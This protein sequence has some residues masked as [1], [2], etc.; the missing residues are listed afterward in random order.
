MLIFNTF[1]TSIVQEW[2]VTHVTATARG[3]KLSEK[4]A[5]ELDEDKPRVSG[6][7][8]RLITLIV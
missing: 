8:E 2:N 5:A 6:S 1:T 3:I 4:V 7:L